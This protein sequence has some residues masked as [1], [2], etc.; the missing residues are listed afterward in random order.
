MKILFAISLLCLTT[1]FIC[2]AQAPERLPEQEF[3]TAVEQSVK[4]QMEHYPATTLQDMYKSFFQDRFGAGHIVSDRKGAEEY[5]CRESDNATRFDGE[6]AE[7]TGWQGKFVRVN[8]SMV[9]DG[10][11]TAGTLADALVRSADVEPTAMEEWTKEWHA[12]ESIISGLYPA[13]PQMKE[14]HE[15]IECRLAK[16]EYVMHHSNTYNNAYERHYR[17]IKREIWQ[18]ELLPALGE[19]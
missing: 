13:L 10:L 17:I 7:P 8:L 19:Q 9:H 2:S 14:Q 1:P 3:R 18:N 11:L 6:E 16:G 5:I 15:E 4:R 12:I